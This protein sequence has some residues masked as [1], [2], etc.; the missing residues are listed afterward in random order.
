LIAERTGKPITF[1]LEET[2]VAWGEWPTASRDVR[3][4]EDLLE[5]QQYAEAVTLGRPMLAEVRD[6]LDRARLHLLM[7]EANVMLRRPAEALDGVVEARG[8]FD[9]AGDSW[10]VVECLDWEAYCL[11]MNHLPGALELAEEALRRCRE[12]DPMP[13]RT[14]A[15]I[16][17]HLGAMHVQSHDWDAGLRCLEAALDASTVLRDLKR[18][19]II[20]HDLTAALAAV[21]RKTE[22]VSRAHR[23]LNLYAALRDVGAMA[24][25][26]ND[27]GV[28]KIMLGDLLGAEGHLCTSLAHF[29]AAAIEIK[30]S[31]TYLSLAEL[32]MAR[33]SDE[34]AEV[35]CRQAIE[36]AGSL[37]ESRNVA[38]AHQY[39]GQIAARRGDAATTDAEFQIAIAILE[40]N[41]ATQRL[42]ECRSA[43][44]DVLEERGD[45]IAANGE[46]RAA[47]AGRS[48]QTAALRV[49]SA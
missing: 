6:D 23:A 32:H 30:K 31:H 8:V 2:A 35:W 42:V 26:E 24:A 4:V 36:L 47:L 10:M 17:S 15:R 19:A 5:R 44:A 7:A 16:L 12:L 45:L 28:L 48:P 40:E 11:Y 49:A 21:G 37:G 1:F 25:M 33:G 22:A 27:I 20:N 34:D 41:Q 9:S 13:G 29:E 39:L 43:Y 18:M 3:E 38:Q 46:L 14:E